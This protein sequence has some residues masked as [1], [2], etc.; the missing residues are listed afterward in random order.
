[1]KR[2]D[3]VLVPGVV[4]LF[5]CGYASLVYG[6]ERTPSPNRAKQTSE[7]DWDCLHPYLGASPPAVKLTSEQILSRVAKKEPIRPP[8]RG[9]PSK[10]VD[11]DVVV[12][13]A[14]RVQCIRMAQGNPVELPEAIDS[15]KKWRF[16]PFRDSKGRLRVFYGTVTVPLP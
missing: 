6:Q 16:R 12:G 7:S 11:L 3:S 1:M 14:G 5:V 9:N 8:G 4:V 13:T 2:S 10:S 15:L